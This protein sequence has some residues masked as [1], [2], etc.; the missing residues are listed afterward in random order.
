[1]GSVEESDRLQLSSI[2]GDKTTILFGTTTIV[3]SFFIWFCEK[4]LSPVFQFCLTGFVLMG[5][6]SVRICYQL[7]QT[8]STSCTEFLLFFL[9]LIC[10]AIFC[11]LWF[12]AIIFKVI[13]SETPRIPIWKLS[14]IFSFVISLLFYLWF[15]VIWWSS[16]KASKKKRRKRRD[17]DWTETAQFQHIIE[18]KD[19]NI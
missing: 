1:M 6:I 4:N 3:W 15:L 11:T 5:C 17:Y 19:A 8:P 10:I 14:T 9:K 16:S 7:K 2:F 13:E 12:L 18:L